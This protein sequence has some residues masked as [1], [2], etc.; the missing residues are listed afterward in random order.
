MRLTPSSNSDWHPSTFPCSMATEFDVCLFL[1]PLSPCSS[2]LMLAFMFLAVPCCVFIPGWGLV[3]KEKAEL[4]P[5]GLL[6]ADKASRVRK[7]Q[8]K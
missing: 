8:G 3:G 6:D 4:I 5:P 2:V 1:G 7:Q